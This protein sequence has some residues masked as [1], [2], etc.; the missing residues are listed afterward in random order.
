MIRAFG[1]IALAALAVAG[2][3]QEKGPSAPAAPVA[4]VPPPAGK[5]WNDVVSAT[6]E[7]GFRMGNPD[8]PVK[9]VEYGSRTCHVCADFDK[10]AHEPLTTRYVAT[11]KVSYEFRDYLRNG[12]DVA[13]ALVG[14]CGGTGPFFTIVNQM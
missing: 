13:A 6:P 1:V 3:S 11:G 10:A 5:A 7:G 2:C 14:G 9:L 8:A 12:A 4:S